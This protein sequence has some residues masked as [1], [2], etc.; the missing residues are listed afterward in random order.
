[1][2][3]PVFVEKNRKISTLEALLVSAHSGLGSGQEKLQG[4]RSPPR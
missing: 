1:M 2:Q 4:G 3:L